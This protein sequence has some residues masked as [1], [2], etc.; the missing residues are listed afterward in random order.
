[1]EAVELRNGDSRVSP[2]VSVRSDELIRSV[3]S[4]HNFD[5]I[6]I[7]GC[8]ASMDVQKPSSSSDASQDTVPAESTGAGLDAL[9]LK[10]LEKTQDTVSPEVTTIS[11]MDQDILLYMNQGSGENLRFSCWDFGGQDTFYG[12]HHL[13]MGRNSVFVLLFNMVWFLA[14]SDFSPHLAFL[15]FWLNSIAAHAADPEDHR[16]DPII[17]V[18]SHKDVVSSPREHERISKML[19]DTFKSSPVWSSVEHFTIDTSSSGKG[20]L[21]FFPVDNIRGSKDPVITEIKKTVQEVVKKEK[22]IKKKIPFNWLNLL[23]R[24][25]E[26]DRPSFLTFDKIV[27]ICQECGMRSTSGASVEDEAL[28]MLKIFN[29]LGQLMHHSEPTLRHLVILDPT[30]YLVEP[31]SRII[32]HHEMHENLNEFLKKARKKEDR[33]LTKLQEKGILDPKLL[34]IVWED[35]PQDIEGL[36][37]LLVKFGFFVPLLRQVEAT[38]TKVSGGSLY[39]VPAILPTRLTMHQSTTTPKLVGYLF[40]ALKKTMEEIRKKGYVTVDDVKREGFFPMG[41]GPALTGEIVSECQCLHDMTLDDIQV[42]S[43]EISA[44]FGRHKFVMRTNME[45][46]MMDLCIMVDSPFIAERVLDLVIKAIKKM[47]PN[48]D[49][50]LAVD[51]GGGVCSNDLVVE[52]PLIILSGPGGLQDKVKNHTA[53]FSVGPG[54]KWNSAKTKKKSKKW[55]PSEGLLEQGYDYFIS[56]RWTTTEWGGMDTD[57]TDGIY[58]KSLFT[59]RLVGERQVQVFLDRH[60]LE[61]GRRF[62]KDFVKALLKSTVV[63]PIVSCTALQKMESLNKDSPIDN[64][65]VEWV[66]VAELQD[67]GALEFCIPVMLGN[68]FETPQ[69]DGKFIS[70]IFTEGI[71][72]KLSEVVVS[73]VVSFVQQVFDDNGIAPSMHLHIRTVKGTV[74]TIKKNL[75]VKAWDVRVQTRGIMSSHNEGGKSDMHIKSEWQRNLFTEVFDKVM[76]CVEKAEVEGKSKVTEVYHEIAPAEVVTEVSTQF[77]RDLRTL[78]EKHGLTELLERVC[79]ALGAKCVEDIAMTNDGDIET[80]TWLKPSERKRFKKLIADSQTGDSTT[81]KIPVVSWEGRRSQSFLRKK[82]E[83]ISADM[84]EDCRREAMRRGGKPLNTSRLNI[85]GEGRSGK[86]AWS[87]SVSNQAFEDT[88]STIG[89]KQSILEVNK[90]DMETK[91][92]GGWSVVEEGTL[93]MK[94]DEAIT[95]L[96]EEIAVTD[97]QAYT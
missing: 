96:A 2:R 31:A 7:M 62:D 86:T 41:L 19:C 59:E 33:L 6:V 58:H 14:E 71:I 22:Y 28:V 16:V 69:K 70:D 40:F 92:E 4:K 55:L 8:G 60:R 38:D 93:I 27:E 97:H 30:I 54:E 5:Q 43:T 9:K 72:A 95:R 17:L 39:L 3:E 21:C 13:Y 88:P 37:R 87:R 57:L 73:T 67:I 52:T 80:L 10:E 90:V 81:G 79:D 12:L 75:G 42:S 64:L 36:T 24:L 47:V 11:R 78:F 49:V 35:R 83:T 94:S 15:A 51:Q 63:V 84:A 50:A 25:Q 18:G 66:I 89:V 74:E 20:S 82:W 61:D 23:E 32:C 77:D 91:C 68:V 29:G 34:D 1:M 65:I 46:Q 53:E 48:L 26:K 44:A 76:D 45:L 56:Y 85:V